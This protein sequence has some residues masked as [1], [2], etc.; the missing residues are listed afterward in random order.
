[1]TVKYL[2]PPSPLGEPLVTAADVAAY[3]GVHVSSIYRMASRA[4]G[5]PVIEISP[6]VR[7]FRPED[8]REYV[9]RRSRTPQVRSNRTEQLLRAP[10]RSSRNVVATSPRKSVHRTQESSAGS[11]HRKPEAR[12]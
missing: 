9:D 2:T 5:I 8:V 10:R 12:T 4:D 3:I 1:M 7:R 11:K 6:G